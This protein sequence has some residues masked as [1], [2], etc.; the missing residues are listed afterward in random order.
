M[1]EQNLGSSPY[2]SIRNWLH[3]LLTLIPQLTLWSNHESESSC[4]MSSLTAFVIAEQCARTAVWWPSVALIGE[5][6]CGGEAKKGGLFMCWLWKQTFV[7]VAW[8]KWCLSSAKANL[9]CLHISQSTVHIHIHCPSRQTIVFCKYIRGTGI[10]NKF[11]TFPPQEAFPSY[12]PQCHF[13]GFSL[14]Q[15]INAPPPLHLMMRLLVV[16]H[17]IFS[18]TL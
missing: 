12:W 4:R 16:S 18:Q 8:S 11:Q 9:W 10:Q 13:L 6:L 5:L 15:S 7:A 2:V 17:L 14:S 3:L 1:W